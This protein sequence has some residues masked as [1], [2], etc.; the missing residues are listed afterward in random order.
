MNAEVV[1][2]SLKPAVGVT[3]AALI[4]LAVCLLSIANLTPAT[5]STQMPLIAVLIFTD[6]ILIA[7]TVFQWVAYLQ[8]Y[9]DFRADQLRQD[10]ISLAAAPAH[11]SA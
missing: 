7:L 5:Q 10:I 3:A 1:S 6:L 8:K 11:A 4:D 2:P 9:V